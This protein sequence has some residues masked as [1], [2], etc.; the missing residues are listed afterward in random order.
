MAAAITF[1]LVGKARRG[2]VTPPTAAPQSLANPTF[3]RGTA[4][5]PTSGEISGCEPL[6]MVSGST[7]ETVSQ[8]GVSIA[9]KYAVRSGEAKANAFRARRNIRLAV[10]NADTKRLIVRDWIAAMRSGSY[11]DNSEADDA[12]GAKYGVSGHQ[13]QCVLAEFIDGLDRIIAGA[14]SM[15]AGIVDYTKTAKGEVFQGVA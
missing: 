4:T 2:A 12:I 8:T 7:C 3:N 13:V 6:G 11:H 10:D 14:R 1:D 5:T 9:R 15:A